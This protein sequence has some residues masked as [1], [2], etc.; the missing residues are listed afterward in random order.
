M[1]LVANAVGMAGGAIYGDA[2][3]TVKLL[4]QITALA[5]LTGRIDD[6][7]VVNYI[8]G[9]VTRHA[10]V[11]FHEDLDKTEKDLLDAMNRESHGRLSN[12]AMPFP[13]GNAE[14][15]QQILV[16]LMPP[17]GDGSNSVFRERAIAIMSALLTVMED[18]H[19][20]YG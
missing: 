1:G 20:R 6:L 18:L 2:K 3:A 11:T 5:S 17:G 4:W 14:G 15:I 12:T 10:D 8:T 16:S 19:Y 9:G 13:V 7:L